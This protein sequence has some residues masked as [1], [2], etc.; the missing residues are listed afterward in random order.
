MPK[1]ICLVSNTAW[2]FTRF[3]MD[4]LKALVSQGYDVLLLA[5]EDE[6]VDQL[7]AVG[8]RFSGLTALASKGMNP[9]KDIQLYREFKRIYTKERPDVIIQYTIKPNVYGTLAA[10][11]LGIPVLAVITGLGYAFINKGIITNVARKLYRFALRKADSVWFLNNDDLQ[12]FINQKLIVAE[13]ALRIPG[14]GINCFDTF[15][16]VL[17]EKHD[18]DE[19]RCT[20]LFIG[21]LLYDK[22][23]R[24][25]VTAAR[26]IKQIYPEANFQV[27][28]YLNVVNP[29]AVQEEELM[30]WVSKGII[31]YLGPVDDVRPFIAEV[32][33]V[34][35]PSY[36]EG[37]S[38]TL[39]ESASMGKLLIASD[40]SGCREL[41]EEGVTGFLC[42][43]KDAKSVAVCMERV[44]KLS[45]SQ[46]KE[47][48]QK[49]RNKMIQEFSVD[50][51]I[52][53]YLHRLEMLIK[54]SLTE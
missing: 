17:V 30:E 42:R 21:R 20:F 5:P 3:R 48:G 47:M 45:P 28:G 37:M 13:K 53:I 1:K 2:S 9:L 11:S 6:H 24:E 35:L 38:T 12:L 43:E 32:D 54:G 33:C 16:P 15:N 51:I 10:H 27:L 8:V 19:A 25:F 31:T 36:R 44:I 22:G 18:H 50:R 7:L 29:A 46:R 4:L 39:Q 52:A 34:V 41:V 23:I 14:E 49:G 26:H 40:I